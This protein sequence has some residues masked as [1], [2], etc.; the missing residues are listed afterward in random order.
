MKDNLAVLMIKEFQCKTQHFKQFTG[1]PMSSVLA[2]QIRMI[3]KHYRRRHKSN[4]RL[5]NNEA[6]GW[7]Y[8]LTITCGLSDPDASLT[9]TIIVIIFSHQQKNG[10]R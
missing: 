3:S 6:Q 1:T 8:K 4:S 9:I 10:H 2:W 7:S 5:I